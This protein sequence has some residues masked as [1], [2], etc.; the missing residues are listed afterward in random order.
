MNR[1]TGLTDELLYYADE[2]E[3][4]RFE[5]EDT[6]LVAILDRLNRANSH[7]AQYI[8]NHWTHAR[9]L[10]RNQGYGK[11]VE[12]GQ[13]NFIALAVQARLV[14]YV[15][16][17][18]DA[19]PS[20]LQKGGRPLLDYALRPFRATLTM[21]P[22]HSARDDPSID[23][24]MVGLLLERGADPN[25]QVHLNDGESVWGLFL[26]S[27]HSTRDEV[28]DSWKKA[29]FCA[30]LL[31]VRAGTRLDYKFVHEQFVHKTVLG[32]VTDVFEPEEA[33]TLESR[34]EAFSAVQKSQNSSCWPM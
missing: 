4:R 10:P 9:D 5:D 21:M 29:W 18:L 1:V 13:C 16:A 3:K 26:I 19:K 20:R 23:V 14:K 31:L 34:M 2:V 27:M 30:S 7:F 28:F 17:K 15:R 6:P 24:N 33:A 8:S 25:Q 32:M 11:F 22:Y 12:G